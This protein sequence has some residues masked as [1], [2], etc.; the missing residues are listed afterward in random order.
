MA[1]SIAWIIVA[2]FF[3]SVGL[4]ATLAIALGSWAADKLVQWLWRGW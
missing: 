4:I 3:F 2:T 1:V